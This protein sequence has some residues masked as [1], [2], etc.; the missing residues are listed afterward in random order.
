MRA[1][2]RVPP[3]YRSAAVSSIFCVSATRLLQVSGVG[4]VV[5]L[6]SLVNIFISFLVLCQRQ[7]RL[8]GHALRSCVAAALVIVSISLTLIVQ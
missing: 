1:A 6:P 8:I 5:K 2:N 4:R 3:S 7:S